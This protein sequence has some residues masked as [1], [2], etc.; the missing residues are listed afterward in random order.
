MLLKNSFSPA[1]SCLPACSPTLIVA[2]WQT[3]AENSPFNFSFLR[4]SSK[5]F[6]IK[7]PFFSPTAPNAFMSQVTRQIVKTLHSVFPASLW[8][9]RSTHT[10][11]YFAFMCVYSNFMSALVVIVP[12]PLFEQFVGKSLPFSRS[13]QWKEGGGVGW[14]GVKAKVASSISQF[15]S[16]WCNKN[17]MPLLLAS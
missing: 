15:L 9:H 2:V 8:R 5:C 11:W 10:A 13:A 3:E 16:N 7:R 6:V 12:R 4:Q 17:W 14:G 1:G